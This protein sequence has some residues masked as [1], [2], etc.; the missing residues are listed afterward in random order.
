LTTAIIDGDLS[1]KEARK[2]LFKKGRVE[3]KGCA[4]GHPT[5]PANS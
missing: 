4:S 3:F 1:V 5:S 2:I